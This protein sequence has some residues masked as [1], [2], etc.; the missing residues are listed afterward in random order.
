MYYERNQ[1][2][3][4]GRKT[5]VNGKVK[6][7]PNYIVGEEK[8]NYFSFGITHSEKKGKGHKNHRLEKN[9]NKQDKNPSY[10]KKKMEI[11]P[12]KSFTSILKGFSMSKNDDD[13]VDSL[14]RKRRDK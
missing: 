2:H 12:K 8:E 13:Y 5:K 11:A 4:R 6:I 7:H 1:R 14:I 10:L 3:F 9:P